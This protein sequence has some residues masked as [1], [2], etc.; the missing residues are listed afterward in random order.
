M[1]ATYTSTQFDKAVEIMC[2]PTRRELQ[3]QLSD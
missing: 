3:D 1:S 2:V